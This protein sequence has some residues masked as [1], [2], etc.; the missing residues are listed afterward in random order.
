MAGV[1]RP[2]FAEM[3]AM[4]GVIEECELRSTFGFMAYHGGALEESTDVIARDAA[5]LCGASYYG[6]LQP[7]S[8]QVH[9]SSIRVSRDQSATL[10]TFL[11]HVEIVV[12]VHGFGRR[13]LPSSLLLGGTNRLLAAHVAGH[14][15]EALPDYSIVDDLDQIPHELRGVHVRNP[16]NAPRMAGIQIELPPRI[17]GHRADSQTLIETLASAALSYDHRPTPPSA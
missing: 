6:V 4:P 17:R 13:P 7:E 1:T 10:A 5:G 9:V 8:V 15:R 12:T 2:T 16:V 11:N 3:L 14:L